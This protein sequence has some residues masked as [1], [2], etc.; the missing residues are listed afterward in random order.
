V[1]KDRHSV[2]G[3]DEVELYPAIHNGQRAWLQRRCWSAAV[4][5]SAYGTEEFV[6]DFQA[7]VVIFLERGV[8]NFPVGTE[9]MARG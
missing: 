9:G 4:G 5:Y 7:G 6:I 1:Y 2:A 8:F 3:H